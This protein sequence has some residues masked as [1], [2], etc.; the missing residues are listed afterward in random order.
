MDLPPYAWLLCDGWNTMYCVAESKEMAI[1]MCLPMLCLGRIA[2]RTVDS[3]SK[4]AIVLLERSGKKRGYL[5]IAS[6]AIMMHHIK[7]K[8][9]IFHK[10]RK[11]KIQDLI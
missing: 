4:T 11:E 9:F 7:E 1:E 2:C 8:P 6:A 5:D 3:V 10:T